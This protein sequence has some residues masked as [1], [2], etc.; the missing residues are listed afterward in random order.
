MASHGRLITDI[1]TV[2]SKSCILPASRR[3]SLGWKAEK[4]CTAH[5]ASINH[6]LEEASSFVKLVAEKPIGPRL[7]GTSRRF[8]SYHVSAFAFS[9]QTTSWLFARVNCVIN[10]EDFA[11]VHLAR[12]IRNDLA[13]TR[14]DLNVD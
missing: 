8:T 5:W 6:H 12:H 7:N 13:E 1:S 3:S 14:D 4:L 10:P 9:L 11:K 2:K